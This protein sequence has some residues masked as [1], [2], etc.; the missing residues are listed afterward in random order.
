MSAEEVYERQRENARR[1]LRLEEHLAREGIPFR[2]ADGTAYD[3]SRRERWVA[4]AVPRH[5]AK[6]LAEAHAQ[7]GLF[8]YDGERFWPWPAGLEEPP[9]PPPPA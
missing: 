2:R 4:V 1:T 8:W 9:S 6:R 7:A 5:E 3:G